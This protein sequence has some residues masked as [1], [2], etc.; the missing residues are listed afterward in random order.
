MSG[1]RRA[2]DG[3][4][5]AEL[6]VALPALV[7]VLAVSLAGVRLGVDRIRVVDAAHVMARAVARGDAEPVARTAALEVA[8]AGSTIAVVTNGGFV[9]AEVRVD[10]PGLLRGLGLRTP[11]TGSATARLEAADSVRT[12]R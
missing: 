6:A 10:P 1:H 9:R 4:A 2:E 11:S 12:V 5:T 7:L 8:P 3:T